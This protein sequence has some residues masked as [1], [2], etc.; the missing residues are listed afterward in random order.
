MEYYIGQVALFP[1]GY[2]PR[3]WMLCNGTVI[4]ISGQERLY[5]L[6]GTRFGGDGKSNF[7]LPDLRNVSPVAEN[8]L[9]KGKCMYYICYDGIYPMRP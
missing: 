3:G 9:V 7:R 2:A 6:I 4:N 8:V 5:S 1:Y